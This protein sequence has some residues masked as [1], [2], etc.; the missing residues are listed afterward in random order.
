VIKKLT[1]DYA[2]S[3][4]PHRLG[5]QLDVGSG[6]RV[7]RDVYLYVDWVRVSKLR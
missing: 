1:G 7:S 2:R 6:T 5:I 4:Y 3:K